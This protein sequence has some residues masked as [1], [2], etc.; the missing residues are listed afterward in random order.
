MRTKNK[1]PNNANPGE[2]IHW[3][4]PLVTRRQF[5]GG[6]VAQV[7]RG[8]FPWDVLPFLSG[9]AAD[10]QCSGGEEDVESCPTP[11]PQQSR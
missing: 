4:K 8:R 5:L 11:N 2:E 7:F 6:V 10:C 9:S 3:R 1:Q